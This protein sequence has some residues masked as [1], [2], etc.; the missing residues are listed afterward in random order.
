MGIIKEILENDKQRRA[1]RA[2]LESWKLSLAVRRALEAHKTWLAE[3]KQEH[4]AVRRWLEGDGKNGREHGD[5]K[6]DGKVGGKVDGKLGKKGDGKVDGKLG[7]KGD[8]KVGG[9]HISCIGYWRSANTA[10]AEPAMA[11]RSL[12]MIEDGNGL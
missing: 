9:R 4:N 12:L 7:K 2:R 11:D 3:N 1:W 10:K 5:G 6:V 8:G